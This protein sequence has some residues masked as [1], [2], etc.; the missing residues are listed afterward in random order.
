MSERTS[1]DVTRVT[2]QVLAIGIL[3][4]AVFWVLRPF[5]ISMVWAGMI[6][7]TTWP[8][9][10]MLQ[11]ALGDKRGPAVA[12]M[13]LA[14]LLVAVVPLLSA[15]GVIIV[16]A[17][18]I[19][20]WLK[21]LAT[22]TV[23]AQPEWLRGLP[24]VGPRAA[25]LW[26]HATIIGVKGLGAY[27][28]PY[29]LKAATIFISQAGTIGKIAVQF[30]LTVA[31]AAVMYARGEKMAASILGFARRLVGDQGE[32]V[33]ILAG[34]AV[35]GVALG[36]VVTAVIQASVGGLGLALAG[37]PAALLLTAVMFVFCL[38]QI[39]PA[40]VLI[41]AV[42]WA[43][44]QFGVLWG[45]ILLVFAVL[46][47][48]LDNFIRPFLIKKGADLPLV[49][50]LGGVIGGLLAF[51]IIG[52]FIGPVILAVAR[53]L[54]NAWVANGPPAAVCNEEGKEL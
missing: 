5:L 26:Q 39:G 45:T 11:A 32:T 22:I 33:T 35:R 28:A 34:K 9:L 40:L 24:L 1:Y 10:L 48:T 15:I 54:L 37:V 13:T 49:L 27:L 20:F 2:F 31:I 12:V 16:R 42:I 44:W 29:T 17:D 6:V 43:Y 38:A 8:V 41:P 21:S 46:A 3:V 23:P 4:T 30:L 14:L 36:V 53:T 19:Y 18:D 51:G 7:V 52:L 25:E 47:L 50:I